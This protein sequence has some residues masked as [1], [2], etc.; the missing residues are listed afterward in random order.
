M[1]P[2][3]LARLLG[4]DIPWIEDNGDSVEFKNT[5]GSSR[6]LTKPV[7]A[8]GNPIQFFV[9]YTLEALRDFPANVDDRVDIGDDDF[10]TTTVKAGTQFQ[11]EFTPAL[12]LH[13]LNSW[14]FDRDQE[15]IYGVDYRVVE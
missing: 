1:D 5:N 3:N 11:A 9:P 8:Q 6:T 12:D 4:E 7:D 10:S 2:F 14:Y 13:C 15:P